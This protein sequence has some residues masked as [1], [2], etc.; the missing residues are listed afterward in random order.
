MSC[1]KIVCFEMLLLFQELST[2]RVYVCMY[3]YKYTM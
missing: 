1:I 3:L 2:L